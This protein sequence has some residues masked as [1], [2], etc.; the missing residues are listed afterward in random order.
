MQLQK[1]RLTAVKPLI[2]FLLVMQPCA[3]AWAAE[4]V[5]SV[6]H[7]QGTLSVQ[8]ADGSQALLALQSAVLEKDVL[9]TEANTYA[10]IKFADNS[11]TV[12][13]PQS[14]LNVENFNY[15]EN[16][17]ENG[18]ILLK[19]VKGGL[20]KVTGLI[21]KAA[22]EKDLM[23]TPV[24]TIGI[25]GTN[26]GLLFCQADCNKIPTVTGEVLHDGLHIDVADGEIAVKN[27]AGDI[28]V[29]SGQ[30]A[31]V[32]DMNFNPQVVPAQQGVQIT[33]PPAFLHNSSNG[34]T[35]DVNHSN[36]QCTIQ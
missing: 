24:A 19:L 26:Y 3:C 11:E 5:G 12:L 2:G 13:R 29:V 15:P 36:G 28:G 8:H 9:S 22:P 14:T 10:R 23:V 27:P 25:R 16:Q 34:K 32:Q 7:L 33:I 35:L 31:F 17:P 18:N 30:F 4:A 21:G 6:T 20:R 1:N